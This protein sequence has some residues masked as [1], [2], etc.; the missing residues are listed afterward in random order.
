M[1]VK[2]S[3]ELYDLEY[4]DWLESVKTTVDC[5]KDCL[6]DT[7]MDVELAHQFSVSTYLEDGITQPTVIYFPEIRNVSALKKLVTMRMVCYS[8]IHLIEIYVDHEHEQDSHD[9]HIVY[10]EDYP[11][12]QDV[13][14][15]AIGELAIP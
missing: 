4:D 12:D 7:D 14:D 8:N 10:F 2:I 11:E 5:I 15:L 9:E 1:K 13:E 6:L 3:C